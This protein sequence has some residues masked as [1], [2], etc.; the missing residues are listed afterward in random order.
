MKVHHA[1]LPLV[2]LA[3][4]EKYDHDK[5]ETEGHHQIS[6]Q[7]VL[8]DDI[9]AITYL[10]SLESLPVA[11]LYDCGSRSDIP[12]FLKSPVCSFLF[13]K[14]FKSGNWSDCSMFI[15]HVSPLK[16]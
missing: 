2:N 9:S 11:L 12:Y 7:I 14:L 5:Y 3:E 1:R 6:M 8:I 16:K 4:V 15:Y 10:W 13:E